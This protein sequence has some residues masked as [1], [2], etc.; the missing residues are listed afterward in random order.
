MAL[1]LEERSFAVSEC[2]RRSAN[3][4]AVL[5]VA[6]PGGQ[7]LIA[8]A[9]GMGG[10]SGGEIASA[11]A[12]EVLRSEVEAGRDLPGAVRMA[13]AAVFTEAHARPEYLGMGTILVLSGITTRAEAE[14][15]EIH[16]DLILEDIGVLAEELERVTT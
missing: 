11:R 6:L 15:S 2:G 16:A 3:Q 7:E 13:N 12:L 8:V 5:V 10:H 4:D 9:D 14:A 1:Q